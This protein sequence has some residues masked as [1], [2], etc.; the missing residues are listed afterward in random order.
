MAKTKGRVEI[1]KN[2]EEVLALAGQVYQ[3]HQDDGASSKLN[4]LEDYNWIT[5]GPTINA[6]LEKH[7]KAE[8][9]KAEMEKMYRER[10]LLLPGII[11]ILQSSKALLKA[12]YLKNPKKLGE[13]GF[14][15]DDTISAKKKV[16]E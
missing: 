12:A 11:S 3:K 8:Y 5:V 16:Q 2:V 9:H 13:W 14:S 10:D 7:K 1:P 4:S 6:C 15:V